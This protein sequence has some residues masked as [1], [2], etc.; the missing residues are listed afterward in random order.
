MGQ[1][2]ELNIS[3]YFY[4]EYFTFECVS[5]ANVAMTEWNG[6]RGISLRLHGMDGSSMK[7]E[8]TLW[9]NGWGP[10]VRLNGTN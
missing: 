5:T 1:W 6:K 3:P 8:D 7:E 4:T 9:K 10:S 2:V